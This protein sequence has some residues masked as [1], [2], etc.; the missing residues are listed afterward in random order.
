MK[1]A[2]CRSRQLQDAPSKRRSPTPIELGRQKVC[3][4]SR[5]EAGFV[6]QV[7][8]VHADQSRNMAAPFDTDPLEYRRLAIDATNPTLGILAAKARGSD[9]DME[10]LFASFEDDFATM[11]SGFLFGSE[12]LLANLRSVTGLDAEELL[13]E[14]ALTVELR[15]PPEPE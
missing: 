12:V 4:L 5:I 1:L 14:I 11:A 13:H 15:F 10:S 2:A 9:A 3:C 8:M 7:F 6:V